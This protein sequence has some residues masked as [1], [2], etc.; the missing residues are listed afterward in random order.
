MPAFKVEA[1]RFQA[2]TSRLRA[3]DLRFGGVLH[4]RNKSRFGGFFMK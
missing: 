2:W 1:A 3:A 4:R